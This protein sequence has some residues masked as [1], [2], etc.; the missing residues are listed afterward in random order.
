M[1]RQ[2]N[3]SNDSNEKLEM[4]QNNEDYT[5]PKYPIKYHYYLLSINKYC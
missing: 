1:Q 3:K 5:Q 4:L 2:Q